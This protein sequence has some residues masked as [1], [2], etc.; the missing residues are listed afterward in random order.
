MIVLGTELLSPVAISVNMT[1]TTQLFAYHPVTSVSR[2][3]PESAARIFPR[4]FPFFSDGRRSPISR[5]SSMKG[6][7]DRSLLF[8]SSV[9]IRRKASAF[10]MPRSSDD[11][12]SGTGARDKPFEPERCVLMISSRDRPA[13]WIDQVACCRLSIDGGG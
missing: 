7:R 6:F 10:R 11:E 2:V 4:V 3:E 8:L 5:S 9:I 12:A 13:S 1:T